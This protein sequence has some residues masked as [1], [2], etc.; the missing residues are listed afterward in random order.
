MVRSMG[1]GCSRRGYQILKETCKLSGVCLL[2]ACS[3]RF[4]VMTKEGEK[5]VG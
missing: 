5:L 4:F 1:G 2:C 3:G